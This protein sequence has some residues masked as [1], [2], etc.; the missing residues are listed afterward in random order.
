[1][2]AV[3]IERIAYGR[4]GL[5][6]KT[7]KSL[8]QYQ[9][10]FRTFFRITSYNV[11]YTKLLRGALYKSHELI[12]NRYVQNAAAVVFIFDPS[13]P[14]VQQEKLFLEKVFNVTPFVMFVM[15]KTDCYDESYNFV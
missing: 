4:I 2:D 15:T 3:K 13:Q 11:C 6:F 8:L 12:T 10:H 1:M 7:G 9:Y 5:S 14:L